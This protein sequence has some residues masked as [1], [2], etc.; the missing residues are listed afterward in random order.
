[1]IWKRLFAKSPAP[2]AGPERCIVI[3]TETTG[4]DVERDVLLAIGGV[5]V[6]ADGVRPDDSFEILVRNG[7]GSS[8]ENIVVHGIGRQAQA[9]GVPLPEAMQAFVG[10]ARDAPVAGFHL[11]FDRAILTRAAQAAGVRLSERVWLDLA[12][13]AS[14]LTLRHRVPGAA[15]RGRRRARHRRADAAA[16]GR[17][18]PGGCPR[19]RGPRQAREAGPVAREGRGGRRPVM[20]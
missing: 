7:L 16:A 12:P 5:A 17:G 10:W 8:K 11:P 13:L 14:A 6:D 2:P 4:L 15:S 3:D 20:R 9:E 18:T 19:L 1:M